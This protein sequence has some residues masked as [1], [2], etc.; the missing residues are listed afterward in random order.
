MT[1]RNFLGSSPATARDAHL[2]PELRRDLIARFGDAPHGPPVVMLLWEISP[3]VAGG[4]WTAAYHLVRRLRQ[5]G[6]DITVVV[7][8]AESD[9]AAEQK[10]FGSEVRVVPLGISVN[11]LQAGEEDLPGPY[12]SGPPGYATSPYGRSTPPGYELWNPYSSTASHVTGSGVVFV[13]VRESSVEPVRPR[14]RRGAQPDGAPLHPPAD[15]RGVRGARTPSGDRVRVRGRARARLG[16]VRRRPET[17]R[18]GRLPVG[19]ARALDRDR[20]ARRRT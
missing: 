8:W 6:A 1:L 11:T 19:R 5:Q 12:G 9:L 3:L 7:P 18:R 14:E 2:D 16:H 15:A 17:R 13:F 4:T 10:P 20:A